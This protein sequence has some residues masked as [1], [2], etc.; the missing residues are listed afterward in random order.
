MTPRATFLMTTYNGAAYLR[1]AV[2]SVL[3]QTV[4]DWRMLI[5]DDCSKDD[6]RAILR[7]YD[8]PR[9]EVLELE[10]NRGQ[11]GALNLALERI[12]TPWIARLDQDDEAAPRRL[13][14]QLA[15][16]DAHP[17]VV[18]VGSW[19]DL[20]DSE[21]RTI[22]AFRPPADP[23]A[24]LADLVERPDANPLAHPATTFR[25]DVARAVGGYPAGVV[26]AQAYGRW[27]KRGARGALANAPEPLTRIREHATQAS[28]GSMVVIRETLAFSE[29][30]DK[31]FALNGAARR[32]WRRA[33]LRYVSELLLAAPLER[34]WTTARRA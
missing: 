6:T 18:A 5:V 24:V 3:A 17:D 30:L 22:G 25:A 27:V 2:D 20:I 33:R 31:S 1:E 8:D 14:R 23:D 7:G 10:T 29:G 12:E 21:G 4:P 19:A 15:Y 11:T 13:E 9:I 26:I 28:R 32:R 16:V 34:D